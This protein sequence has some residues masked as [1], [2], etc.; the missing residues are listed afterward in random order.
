[1]GALHTQTVKEG[2]KEYFHSLKSILDQLEASQLIIEMKA[3]DA[4][5]SSDMLLNI[6]KEGIQSIEVL[7]SNGEEK[8]IETEEIESK[9]SSLHKFNSLEKNQTRRCQLK[10]IMK[11]ILEAANI[12]NQVS[13]DIEHEIANQREI[14]DVIK[15][16]LKYNRAANK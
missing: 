6:I 8:G 15:C 10:E 13:R 3:Y 7:Q 4:I 11:P 9:E 1:M 14:I 2:S 16:K 12:S 5:N